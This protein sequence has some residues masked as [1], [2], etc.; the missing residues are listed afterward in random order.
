MCSRLVAFILLIALMFVVPS[1]WADTRPKPADDEPSDVATVWFDTLYEM[2]KSEA[3][4]FAEASR[5][6]GI[7]AV[8]LYEAIVPGTLDNRSLVDQ[9]DGLT[10]VP[11]PKEHLKYHWPTVANAALARTIRGIFLSLKPENLKA[12]NALEER[13][14]DRFQDEVEEQAYQRSVDQGQR[15]ADAILSWAA[16]DGF[17]DFNN[18]PYVPEREPGAWEPT[19]PGFMRNPEQPCWGQ[20]RP[21]VLT[22][23]E[24]CAPPGH[25]EFSTDP[26]SAFYAAA[27]E[28][29]DTAQTLTDEQRT[30]AQYWND[31]VGI[32]GTSSGHWMAIVGQIARNDGLSLAAAGEA[33]AKLG[34]AVVDAFITIFHAKYVYNLERPVTYIQDHIDNTWLPYL[35]TPPNPSYSSGHSTQSSAAAEVLTD[36]F[37]HKAFTDTLHTDHHLMPPQE[38]RTFSS[39]NEAAA[40]AAVSR[41]Y[42]GI[43]Y[44][45]DNNDG[46]SSGQCVG[47]AINERVHFTDEDD[48]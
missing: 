32:T 6:Y 26:E 21:M 42:G 9:L 7:S 11:Q 5:I 38:P 47:E 4:A 48:H 29:Y 28:V 17:P 43:H 30:I 16:T 20:L 27:L 34:I 25:P 41:L 46:R 40:E 44:A 23:N 15:V 3:T 18:C 8:A 37:G 13:F 45:F 14:A 2:V 22:S 1:T 39:F 24:E 19:P 31:G 12:I 33:Y 35:V 36:L 10:S